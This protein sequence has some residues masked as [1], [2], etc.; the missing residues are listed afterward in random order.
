[1]SEQEFGER[2]GGL[3]LR[4]QYYGTCKFCQKISRASNSNPHS[5]YED[6]IMQKKKKVKILDI[7]DKINHFLLYH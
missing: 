2:R 7:M 5:D 3:N 6:D 4:L 1:M